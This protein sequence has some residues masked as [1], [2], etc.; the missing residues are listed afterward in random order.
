MEGKLQDSLKEI[1][2]HIQTIQESKKEGEYYLGNL[3]QL[4]RRETDFTMAEE[5]KELR[6]SIEKKS[7]NLQGLSKL[8]EEIVGKLEDSQRQE[9]ISII[10]ANNPNKQAVDLLEKKEKDKK[11]IH[12][13]LTVREKSLSSILSFSQWL[14]NLLEKEGQLINQL[15]QEKCAAYE[16][17]IK[18]SKSFF[19]ERSPLSK[20][21]PVRSRSFVEN[22]SITSEHASEEES[23]GELSISSFSESSDSVLESIDSSNEIDIYVTELKEGKNTQISGLLS[24]AVDGLLK[25][26]KTHLLGTKVADELKELYNLQAKEVYDHLLLGAAGLELVVQAIHDQRTDHVVLGFRTA[27]LH[28]YYAMEQKLSQGIILLTFRKL[29]SSFAIFL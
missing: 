6:S 5:E 2:D 25:A 27:L 9:R 26:L 12:N 29:L 18:K 11:E 22:F 15:E 13:T 17:A 20:K 24:Q 16:A 8:K 10:R 21:S 23:E 19:K 1:N 14:V 4:K 3:E 28:C 7:R